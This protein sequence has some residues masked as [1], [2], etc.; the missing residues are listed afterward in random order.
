MR[1]QNSCSLQSEQKSIHSRAYY[2]EDS[3]V[4]IE[5]SGP[6]GQLN[7]SENDLKPR[8][9]VK[10]CIPDP[11]SMDAALRERLIQQVY[12]QDSDGYT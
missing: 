1:D 5:L 11:D 10:A 9:S 6:L 8:E 12:S 3:G 7:I 4:D 2:R